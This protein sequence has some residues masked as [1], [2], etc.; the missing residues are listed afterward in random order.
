MNIRLATSADIP[1]ITDIYNDAVIKR[2]ATC[3][4]QIKDLEERKNWFKQF[5]LTHP[6]WVIEINSEIAGY[7][8]LF[9]YSPK[10]GYRFTVENSLYIAPQYQGQGLGRKLLEHT[11]NEA[12]RFGHRYIEAK[13]FE[14][15]HMSLKLHQQMG[16]THAGLQEGIANLDGKWCNVVLL[17]FRII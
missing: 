8:C 4:E 6:C 11:I 2:L 10:S 7:G 9:R 13:I 3:D 16:F 17:K 12:T 15:N 1:Q 5:D 14:H